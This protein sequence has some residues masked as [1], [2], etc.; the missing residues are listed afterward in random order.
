MCLVRFIDMNTQEP[1]TELAS[2][3]SLEIHDANGITEAIL[4]GLNEINIDIE[5]ASGPY[6]VC[7][8]LDW[9]SENIGS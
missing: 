2:I 9:V 3:Q 4:R 1:T 7:V 5:E 6:L 8:N